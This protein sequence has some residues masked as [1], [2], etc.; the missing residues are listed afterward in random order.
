MSK[1]EISGYNF[2]KKIAQEWNEKYGT[3]WNNQAGGFIKARV[4]NKKEKEIRVYFGDAGYARLFKTSKN[5][6]G[7]IFDLKYGTLESVK[8]IISEIGSSFTA[9]ELYLDADA[10]MSED[11]LAATFGW[12]EVIDAQNDVARED[13]DI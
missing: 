11:Q 10:V 3:E 5:Q 6:I 4:W 9:K 13:W 12:A 7:F 1:K 2:C 8:N